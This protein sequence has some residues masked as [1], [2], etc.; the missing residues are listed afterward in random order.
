MPNLEQVMSSACS[1][2]IFCSSRSYKYW[3]GK[4][5]FVRLPKKISLTKH[6][7]LLNPYFWGSHRYKYWQGKGL[8]VRLPK[9]ISLTKH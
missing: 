6:Y 2:L 3:Q 4:G 5:L 7:S 8:F 9:K 1:S